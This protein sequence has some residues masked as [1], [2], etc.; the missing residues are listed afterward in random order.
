VPD[1]LGEIFFLN[2]NP[3]NVRT[4]VYADQI[5]LLTLKQ[6]KVA[7]DHRTDIDYPEPRIRPSTISQKPA[8]SLRSAGCVRKKLGAIVDGQLKGEDGKGKG[9]D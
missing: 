4:G 3:L 6:T 5:K 8:I 9:K 1:S 2:D 7:K